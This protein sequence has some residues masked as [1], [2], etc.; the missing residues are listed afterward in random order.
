MRKG[1]ALAEFEQ[2]VLLAILR[3][4][5]QA[6]G[7]ELGTQNLCAPIASFLNFPDRRIG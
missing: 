7:S 2:I 1:D 6:Y 5:E 3:L 4:R